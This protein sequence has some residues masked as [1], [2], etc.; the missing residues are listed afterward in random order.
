MTPPIEQWKCVCNV[1]LLL[2]SVL[3]VKWEITKCANDFLSTFCNC[4]SSFSSVIMH[5]KYE[6][7]MID[8]YWSFHYTNPKG[9][10]ILIIQMEKSKNIQKGCK[11]ERKPTKMI[12]QKMSV[13]H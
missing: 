10:N 13:K 2:H 1:E 7:N 9:E 6:N 5:R 4:Q 11:T 3:G 8:L 12:K